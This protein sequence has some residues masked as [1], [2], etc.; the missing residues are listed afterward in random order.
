MIDPKV[1]PSC[2][3]REI[4]RIGDLSPDLPP[5]KRKYVCST[6][7]WIWGNEEENQVIGIN[8]PYELNKIEY[9]QADVDSAVWRDI[10]EHEGWGCGTTI[11][12]LVLS[13]LY[14][15]PGIIFLIWKLISIY[16]NN[17]LEK[18][19]TPYRQ[20]AFEKTG[21]EVMV[22]MLHLGGHPN[23]PYQNRVV[24]GLRGSNLEFY[25]Y[26]LKR[27]HSI[28]V[29]DVQAATDIRHIQSTT[30][31]SSY[32]PK[33][34]SIGSSVGTTNVNLH[35][36]TLKLG[37][38]VQGKQ[39]VAEFETKPH[40][41]LKIITYINKHRTENTLTT[42]QSAPIQPENLVK[43]FDLQPDEKKC[44]YCAEIIKREA[45]KC[46]YCQSDLVNPPS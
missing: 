20:L 37:W 31:G 34:S 28:L 2:S 14:L 6:C 29:D 36:D 3:S 24:M 21:C 13:C 40:D 8:D 16:K 30:Y 12:F 32:T 7:H 35:P 41:P 11:A 45:I 27:L 1:C 4:N 5:E 42:P 23:L 22:S 38:I 25:N 18:E 39:V 15:I 44:P 10:P 9:T 46:R 33:N 19:T 17:Q 26:D 43:P